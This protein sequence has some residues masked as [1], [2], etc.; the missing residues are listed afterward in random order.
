MHRLCTVFGVSSVIFLPFPHFYAKNILK[1]AFL[2]IKYLLAC[3][4]KRLP[5]TQSLCTRRSEWGQCVPLHARPLMQYGNQ[6]PLPRFS[7]LPFFYI[8]SLQA[9]R[10]ITASTIP[11][12]DIIVD[13]VCLCSRYSIIPRFY[14]SFMQSLACLYKIPHICFQLFP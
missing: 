5:P 11:I 3:L 10:G 8:S 7:T 12:M 4:F 9:G 14:D 2:C 13:G 6:H 1:S